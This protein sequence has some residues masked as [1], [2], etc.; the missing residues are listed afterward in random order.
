MRYSV[1]FDDV[2]SGSVADTFATIAALIAADTTGHRC[3]LLS[4]SLGPSD[5]A[6]LDLSL[7]IQ[8]RR[9]NDVSAGGNGTGT[10]F[11][12]VPQDSAAVAA[13]ITAKTDCSVEPTTYTEPLWQIDMNTRNSIIK[14]WTPEE[15]PIINQDQLL[16]LLVAPRSANA[17]TV[18]GTLEFEQF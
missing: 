14:Q 17:I 13:V 11:T 12:P 16:G 18:S 3:R 2:A 15:A 6:P 7:A 9:V 10:A 8:L 5:D 4:I 1:N